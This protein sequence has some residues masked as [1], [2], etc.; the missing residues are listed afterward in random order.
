MARLKPNETHPE[1]YEAMDAFV[2]ELD[3]PGRYHRVIRD[4]IGPGLGR[5]YMR[6]WIDQDHIDPEFMVDPEYEDP[7]PPWY[8]IDGYPERGGDD[9][10]IIRRKWADRA[11]LYFQ[12][13]GHHLMHIADWLIYSN[14]IGAPWIANV[15]E[16]G[17]PRKLMK[18]QGLEQL[19]HE[20]DKGLRHRPRDYGGAEMP[21]AVIP[22]PAKDDEVEVADL[23]VGHM[24][25]ELQTSRALRV[26]GARMR[27]CVGHGGYDYIL[28]EAGYRL[29]S[30][31]DP[32][33][34]PLATLEIR[35][36]V[37]RQFRGPGNNDPSAAVVDLL[38]AYAAEQGWR[39]Y[40]EAA[41]GRYVRVDD[42]LYRQICAVP[43]ADTQFP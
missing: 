9:Q 33:G 31:R 29:L 35:G 19:V 8:R 37:V 24:L 27:H 32:N 14:R 7:D 5:I 38:S 12:W 23:G 43:P 34:L 10:D 17:R 20:A 28:R 40:E 42:Q 13:Y 36:D 6:F 22:E 41:V 3:L 16:Q 2:R 21:G 39:G 15:D 25:V 18:C 11:R 30:V 1:W 4:L 26:E